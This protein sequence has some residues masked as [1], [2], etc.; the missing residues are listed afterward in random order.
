MEFRGDSRSIMDN[1]PAESQ[2]PSSLLCKI[3]ES[4]NFSSTIRSGV[5]EIK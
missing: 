1:E 4:T 5:V 3:H 2:D